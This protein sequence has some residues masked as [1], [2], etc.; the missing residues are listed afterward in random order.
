[1]STNWETADILKAPMEVC[2]QFDY[3]IGSEK[4]KS[5]YSKAKKYQWEADSHLDWTQTVDPSRPLMGDAVGVFVF[6]V[7][8]VQKLNASQQDTLR[9][10]LTAHQ[11]SQILHGEQGALMTAA[12]LTHAV[13]DYEGKLFGATQTMDEARHVEVFERYIRKL[14]IVYPMGPLK[15]LIDIILTAN[16]WVKVAIGMNMIVESMALATFHNVLQ[17]TPCPLLRKLMQSV[18]R[19][20]SRHVAFGALYVARTIADMHPDEREDIADFAFSAVEM[21]VRHE[22]STPPNAA[23]LQLLDNCSIDRDDFAKSVQELVASGEKFETPLDR[24]HAMRHLTLPALVRVG[25]VTER[26]RKRFAEARI[27]VWDDNSTLEQFEAANAP[28]WT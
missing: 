21:I 14:A 11:L 20:E 16:H 17:V 7:P 18:L 1:M 10:H 19:D 4:L 25:A 2:W 24:V 28:N 9:A 13:P 8:L 6:R 5:L 27:Q 23:F 12:T 3:A 26:T 22:V 15:T